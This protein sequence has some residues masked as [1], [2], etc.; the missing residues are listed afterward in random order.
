VTSKKRTT[1]LITAG[2]GTAGLGLL[3]LAYY[4]NR[5]KESGNLAK[6]WVYDQVIAN[7]VIDEEEVAEWL[8]KARFVSSK[9]AA[10]KAI[11]EVLDN[12]ASIRKKPK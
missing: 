6:A 8:L 11:G 5:E 10:K 9:R 4:R 2:L 7:K 3:L 12:I 1:G